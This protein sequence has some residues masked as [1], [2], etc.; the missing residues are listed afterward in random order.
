MEEESRP[1]GAAA[2]GGAG[3]GEDCERPRT[4]PGAGAVSY[5]RSRPK[6]SRPPAGR[7][8]AGAMPGGRPGDAEREEARRGFRQATARGWPRAARAGPGR[9]A[10]KEAGGSAVSAAATP[11][12]RSSWRGPGGAVRLSLAIAEKV[13]HVSLRSSREVVPDDSG[14]HRE[15]QTP[16]VGPI[17]VGGLRGKE[18]PRLPLS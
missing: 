1:P 5:A 17:Y 10:P 8:P 15:A 7:R 18:W 11:P 16:G 3:G 2:R 9:R 4:P 14:G 12:G 6:L 13:I